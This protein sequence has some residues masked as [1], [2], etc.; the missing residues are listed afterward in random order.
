MYISS[1]PQADSGADSN[2][3]DE[4]QDDTGGFVFNWYHPDDDE[5]DDVASHL[6]ILEHFARDDV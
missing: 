4:E 6:P 5:A 1:P 2:A 3:D